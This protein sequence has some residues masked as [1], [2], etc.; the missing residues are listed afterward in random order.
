MKKEKEQ[1]KLFERLHKQF[2]NKVVCPYD[3]KNKGSYFVYDWEA[4]EN[5]GITYESGGKKLGELGRDL[6]ANAITL[7]APRF[8]EINQNVQQIMENAHPLARNCLKELAGDLK[9]LVW[10]VKK[11]ED[12][13]S[14]YCSDYKEIFITVSD[15]KSSSIDEIPYSY[16]EGLGEM[17]FHQIRIGNHYGGDIGTAWTCR[18]L[19]DILKR[20]HVSFLENRRS[21]FG[22]ALVKELLSRKDG[23]W[24]FYEGEQLPA[25]EALDAIGRYR[26]T[27]ENLI[28][29]VERTLILEA[30]HYVELATL[31]RQKNSAEKSFDQQ[32]KE[33]LARVGIEPY[34]YD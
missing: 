14:K 34:F 15:L 18:C 25:I 20:M 8:R 11:I 2:L 31:K 17:L 1:L 22:E 13:Q 5:G 24:N 4:N 7:Y 3:S 33:N 9:N 19:D 16:E 21:E 27:D 30:N 23:F 28:T 29:T 6:I 32:K 26:V 10:R 12:G